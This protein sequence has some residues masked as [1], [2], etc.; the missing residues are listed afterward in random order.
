MSFF[1]FVF[2]CHRQRHRWHFSA[3]VLVLQSP[4]NT[5]PNSRQIDDV[6]GNNIHT[7]PSDVIRFVSWTRVTK[8][9]VVGRMERATT[10]A[11]LPKNVVQYAD[12]VMCVAMMM[13]HL[14]SLKRDQNGLSVLSRLIWKGT[15]GHVCVCPDGITFVNMGRKSEKWRKYIFLCDVQRSICMCVWGN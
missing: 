10:T 12:D 7:T 11:L 1:C 13:V 6:D 3:H 8:A 9:E 15:C 4:T 2:H 5:N 14:L